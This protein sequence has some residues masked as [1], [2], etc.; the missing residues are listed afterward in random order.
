MAELQVKQICMYL[1]LADLP[2]IINTKLDQGENRLTSKFSCIYIW[3]LSIW[4]R[5]PLAQY[6]D[7]IYWQIP[8]RTHDYLANS[9]PNVS[10]VTDEEPSPK[11]APSEG[12]SRGNIES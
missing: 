4:N 9:I 8:L 1:K 11:L 10:V 7:H 12:G 2:K 6:E 5:K 3:E